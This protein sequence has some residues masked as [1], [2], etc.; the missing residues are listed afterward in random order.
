LAFIGICLFA[1][2]VALPLIDP[3]LP[4]HLATGEW[5]VRHRALPYTEPW[6]W[7]RP[8]APFLAYSWAIE[9]FYYVLDMRFGPAALHVLH[10]I[11]YAAAAVAILLLG[12]TA[13]WRAWT[14]I[15][16]GLGSVAVML[17]VT[18]YLRP[19]S[20]LLVA[21][22]LVWMLVLRARDAERERWELLGLLVVSAV[23]ANTHLLFPIA[24]APC[25]ALV[26]APPARRAKFVTIPA[27]IVCGW[28]L[29]PYIPHLAEM[30]R[31][32]F[33]ANA[34][35]TPPSPIHEYK[36][37][38]I[39]AVQ[40][41]F[42]WIDIPLIL[43]F[44]PCFAASRMRPL[45]RTVFG[46]LWLAGFLMFAL[47]VR[48]LIVWWLL[49]LPAI[50]ICLEGISS[51]TLPALRLTTRATLSAV[52]AALALKAVDDLG[53]PWL[54]AGT[55]PNRM[56]P[57]QG[58][59]AIE[60]IAEWLDCSVHHDVGGRLVTLFKYGGYIPWR[61]PYLS[62][63]IDGRTFFPDSVARPE[64]YISPSRARIAL[65]P[66]RSADL[67]ILPLDHRLASVLDTALGWQRL[68]I[69]SE[70]E[71]R[72]SMIGLWVSTRWWERASAVGRPYGVIPLPHHPSEASFG[73]NGAR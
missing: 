9:V 58:A 12:R 6:A 57:S 55:L 4:I 43:A 61:L 53:D 31:L 36:P 47:A 22:P 1:T 71:G 34:L 49:I 35:L 40:A 70:M 32:Y 41:G 16:I 42:D 52:F 26:L 18:P 29:T 13:K 44:I 68:A 27:A 11:T 30:Y 69:T 46:V 37:G 60:P 24:L 50:A 66:W 45:E 54:R 21:I 7:T 14:T 8:G 51:P 15:I 65:P 5:I 73:C 62:Q 38:F 3:D 10:G 48:A 39:I 25:V 56:L 17:T 59:H 20:V 33:G 67:A 28:L 63:S 64:M 23:L 72:A 2:G 19:Q